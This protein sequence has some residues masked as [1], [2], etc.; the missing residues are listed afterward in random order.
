MTNL[1]VHPT[2]LNRGGGGGGVGVRGSNTTF[3]PYRNTTNFPDYRGAGG[4]G[5]GKGGVEEEVVMVDLGKEPLVDELAREMNKCV[6]AFMGDHGHVMPKDLAELGQSVT[7]LGEA[8][9]ARLK[10]N[11]AAAAAATGTGTSTDTS[12]SSGSGGGGGWSGPKGVTADTERHKYAGKRIAALQDLL[13][14]QVIG[15]AK[16]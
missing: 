6:M 9:A 8:M 12:A 3:H 1:G 16:F 5:S 15:R 10:A 14:L 11:A 13:K 2:R 4:R 7:A